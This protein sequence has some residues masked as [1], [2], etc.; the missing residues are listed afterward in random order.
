ME[1]D[2]FLPPRSS[3]ANPRLASDSQVFIESVQGVFYNVQL[4]SDVLHHAFDA[5]GVLQDI[6]TLGVGVVAY[7]EWAANGLGKLSAHTATSFIST[8][9]F[10]KLHYCNIAAT[11]PF[12]QSQVEN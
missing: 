8:A 4:M 3:S 6:H 1:S 12:N 9:K 7:C 2:A 10:N 5:V 11:K